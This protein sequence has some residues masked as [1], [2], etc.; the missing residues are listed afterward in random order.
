MIRHADG[1]TVRFAG[2]AEWR[3]EGAW[4]RGVET[5]EIRQGGQVF[6]ARR[7]TLWREG[8]DGI[9]VAFGDGRPFHVIGPD[10]RAHHDC[11]PDTYLLRYDLSAWPRWSVRWRVTGP[12]KDYRALTRYRR[13]V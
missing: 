10:G 12:R 4:L 8:P 3:P 5:G 1:A 13:D 11:A 7:E 6:A 2:A 9:E